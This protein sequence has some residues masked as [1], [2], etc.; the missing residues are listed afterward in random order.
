MV[1][2]FVSW[3]FCLKKEEMPF[4]RRK[5]KKIFLSCNKKREN[6]HC[7]EEEEKDG[8]CAGQ[9]RKNR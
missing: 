2:F 5:Q 4:Y 7:I 1:L 8:R 6:L 3:K 9:W